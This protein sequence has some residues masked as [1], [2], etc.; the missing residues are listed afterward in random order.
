MGTLT[1]NAEGYVL[2][3]PINGRSHSITGLVA[4]TYDIGEHWH[5][6]LAGYGGS[7][8]IVRNEWQVMAKISYGIRPG[9]SAVV[10]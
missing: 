3:E 4:G 7:T 1:A 9:I 10:Q 5:T 6:T 8:P 2:K